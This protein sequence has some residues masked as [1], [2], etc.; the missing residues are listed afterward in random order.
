MYIITVTFSI[1]PENMTEFLPV[2]RQQA[3]NSL[4]LEPGCHTFH[5]G[6]AESNP[7]L[8][9]LYEEYTDRSA[10]EAHLASAHFTEFN[11][12]ISTWVASKEVNG[13]YREEAV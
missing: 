12:L 9:F 10:F 13:W 5:V 6:V 11:S 3:K 2:M 4:S 8:V 1:H 7:N